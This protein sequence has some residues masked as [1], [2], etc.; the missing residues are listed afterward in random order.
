MIIAWGTVLPAVLAVLVICLSGTKKE[1]CV[2][3]EQGAKKEQSARK[4]RYD[5][6]GYLAAVL[7]ALLFIDLVSL[8]SLSQIDGN[9]Y[10]LTY[11]CLLYTSTSSIL[12]DVG[13]ISIPDSILNKPGRLT[14]EEFEVMKQHTIKSC[15]IL[16][17]IPNIMDEGVYNYSYD[18]CRHHHERWDGRGYP[19]GLKGDD[20]TIWS[21]M[22]IRDSNNAENH[23][24]S[25]CTQDG[26]VKERQ[27]TAAF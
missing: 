22:C 7:A 20:I 8:Y 19:D 11:A 3:K 10:M 24:P 9:Y 15:E 27:N 21:Q 1:K 14:K 17:N 5:M 4:E 2:K 18:I 25:G 26:L 16:K 12:H 6:L 23:A 13:K